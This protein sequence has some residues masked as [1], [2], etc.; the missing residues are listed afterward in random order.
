MTP[1]AHVVASWQRDAVHVWG[2]DGVQ[3]MPPYWLV[4]GFPPSGRLGPPSHHG[5]H[6]SLDV[7]TP[8]G[9]RLRPVSVRLDA[10]AGLDWLRAEGLASDSVR[11]FGAIAALAERV[12]RAGRLHARFQH[13]HRAE[14]PRGP[15]RR[16]RDALGADERPGRRDASRQPRRSDARDLPARRALGRRRR[17]SPS[18]SARSTSSSWTTPPALDCSGPAGSP[19][20]RAADQRPTPSSG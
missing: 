19:I 15:R 3:T 8:S 4:G 18:S 5:F 1:S 11:W 2:W 10:I 9:E 12:V 13:T 14:P 16:R 20:S 7:V 6:S 17:T